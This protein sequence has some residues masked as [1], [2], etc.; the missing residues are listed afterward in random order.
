M[1]INLIAFTLCTMAAIMCFVEYVQNDKPNTPLLL[2]G[3][4][5]VVLATINLFDYLS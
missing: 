1:I 4:V 2:L 3:F 5:N